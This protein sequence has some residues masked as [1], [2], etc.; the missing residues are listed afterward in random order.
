MS[1]AASVAIY[2]RCSSSP[3][4]GAGIPRAASTWSAICWIG[5]ESSGSTRSARG[6]PG[7]TSPRCH[8][9]WRS[10]SNGP[11][12]KVRSQVQEPASTGIPI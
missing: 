11:A 6:A 4:T 2:P 9:G 5:T 3:M 12:R 10:S 1:E 7:S 8:E